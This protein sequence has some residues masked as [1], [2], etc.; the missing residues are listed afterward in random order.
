MLRKA[1]QEGSLTILEYFTEL[2]P[3]YRHMDEVN[4]LLYNYRSLLIELNKYTL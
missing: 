3:V 4:E 2:D 1:L